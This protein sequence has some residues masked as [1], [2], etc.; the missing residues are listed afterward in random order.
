MGS[1]ELALW[2]DKIVSKSKQS[3]YLIVPGGGKFADSI[4]NLQK[5]YQFDDVAAHQMA[6]LAM[7]QY[8]HYLLDINPDLIIVNSNNAITENLNKQQPLLWLPNDLISGQVKV[9]SSWDMTSDSISLWLAT[10]LNAEK[11]TLVK[12][13]ELNSERIQIEKHIKNNDLDK[14]FLRYSKNYAGEITFYSKQ[15][16]QAF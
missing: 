5:T 12:S 16:Y 10:Q 1:P 15:Q 3:N 7:C 14:A 6:M 2:L 13:K 9:E 11:L 8:A 4:R